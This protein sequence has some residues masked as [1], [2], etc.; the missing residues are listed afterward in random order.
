M[1]EDNPPRTPADPASGDESLNRELSNRHIQLIAIGGAIGTGLFMGSGKAIS[2][3]GP[4]LLLAYLVI[5]LML[6]FVMRAMGEMLLHDLR[7]KSFQ[8]FSREMIGPWAGFFAGWTYW[9]LWVVTAAAEMIAIVGYFDFW[10]QNLNVSMIC[11]AV[12]LVSLLGSNLLTVRLFGELEFWFALIKIIAIIALILVGTYMVATRFTSPDGTVASVTYL[13]SHG[14]VFP[15]GITGFL[16][17]FQLAIFSFIGTELIGT[18]AAETADPHTTLPKAINAIPVR[19]VVFYVLALTVIMSVTPWDRVNPEMS[20]FVNVFNLA[21]LVAAASVM[22][23]VVLTSAS[24][25]SNSGIFSTSRMLYGLAGSGYA[26]QRFAKLSS[27]HVPANAL[28]LSG[29]L[30]FIAFP[31][32]KL[33]GTVMRAFQLISSV[34][35]ILVLFVWSLIMVAYIMYRRKFPQPH[36]ESPFRVPGAPYMPWVVLAFFAAMLAVLGMDSQTRIA[37]VLTPVWFLILAVIWN[38]SAKKK[39]V[40]T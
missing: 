1:S 21:G 5:G 7:Y 8:D 6:F 2:L 17:A 23:F 11:T 36:R 14:G 18:A 28:I 20:P 19:I 12:L 38:K 34:S 40:T 16:A 27:R 30:V 10:I 29:A 26:S 35:S 15:T 4:A 32:L 33:G 3:A 22:N 24:S 31:V 13:W 9:I 25:S 39:T 37:L